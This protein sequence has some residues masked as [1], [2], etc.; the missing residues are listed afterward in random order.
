[1]GPTHWPN[2]IR[3]FSLLFFFFSLT[4]IF[5]C[6]SPL[7][8]FVSPLRFSRCY[9][10]K[11]L[12]EPSDRNQGLDL[13]SRS[14]PSPSAAYLV[15]IVTQ[16][17]KI[18]FVMSQQ[19]RSVIMD[20]ANDKVLSIVFPAVPSWTWLTAIFL[21]PLLCCAEIPFFFFGFWFGLIWDRSQWLRCLNLRSFATYI[22]E[23]SDLS[24]GLTIFFIFFFYK[25]S[26]FWS[27]IKLLQGPNLCFWAG[28]CFRLL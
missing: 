6:L 4:L 20:M 24:S 15:G 26:K 14:P 3:L 27:C 12:H 22:W 19:R 16:R 9:S 10:P 1:M 25:F 2:V 5:L 18:S 8:F 7:F 11:P 28:F 17:C 21:I 13:Q 23:A